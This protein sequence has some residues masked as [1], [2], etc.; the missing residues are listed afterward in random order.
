MKCLKDKLPTRNTLHDVD[1]E[2]INPDEPGEKNLF[3]IDFI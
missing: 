2:I 1:I 3:R